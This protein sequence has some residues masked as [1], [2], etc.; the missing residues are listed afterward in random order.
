MK[1]ILLLGTV[2]L[3]MVL[4]AYGMDTITLR[5]APLPAVK[6]LM[7]ELRDEPDIRKT[8]DLLTRI[9][10]LSGKHLQ[11]VRESRGLCEEGTEQFRVNRALTAY[12]EIFQTITSFRDFLTKVTA[13]AE[14]PICRNFEPDRMLGEDI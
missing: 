11:T 2:S 5:L 13:L 10:E 9:K 4:P 8:S 1:R 7:A 3:L 12:L 14:K 6:K